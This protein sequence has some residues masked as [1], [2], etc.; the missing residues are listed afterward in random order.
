MYIEEDPLDPCVGEN[1]HSKQNWVSCWYSLHCCR[2]HWRSCCGGWGCSQ[3]P[4][5]CGRRPGLQR[6]VLAQPGDPHAKPWEIRSQHNTQ[7]SFFKNDLTTGC[8]VILVRSAV[9]IDMSRSDM[10]YGPPCAWKYCQVTLVFIFRSRNG[11][12]H[13]Y[14]HIYETF[15]HP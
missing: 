12:K 10:D 7:Q 3:H 4:V 6:R 5:D 8:L 1:V 11:V 14:D 9:R 15:V 13:L 2:C